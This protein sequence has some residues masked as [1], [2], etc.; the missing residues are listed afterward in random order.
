[1][2]AVVFV[3]L[4]AC[5]GAH[6]KGPVEHDNSAIPD[7][8]YGH[9]P[10]PLRQLFVKPGTDLWLHGHSD[11]H[12]GA[13]ADVA[14]TP[15][16]RVEVELLGADR[17]PVVSASSP[18]DVEVRTPERVRLHRA[19]LCHSFYVHIRARA[20]VSCDALVHAVVYPD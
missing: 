8:I 20:P 3:A 7:P 18:K 19:A 16:G 17:G 13:G 6:E 12:L 2:R 11:C 4:L 1:M 15:S 5:T 14:C 10:V 9:E